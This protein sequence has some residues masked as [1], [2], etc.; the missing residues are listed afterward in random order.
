VGEG[1]AAE[2]STSERTAGLRKRSSTASAC[3]STEQRNSALHGIVATRSNPSAGDFQKDPGPV[4]ARARLGYG[5]R[6]RGV[7]QS[8][9][10]GSGRAAGRWRGKQRRARGKGKEGTDVRGRP[11]SEGGNRGGGRAHVAAVHV[12]RKER[13]LGLGR[14]D[15]AAQGKKR[16]ERRGLRGEGELGHRG[17]CGSEERKGPRER[18]RKRE[19]F[20]AGR[21]FSF[22][23]FSFSFLPSTI[24]TI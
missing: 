6:T 7:R 1:D 14:G 4:L 5:A 15:A 12:R 11:G 10:M 21:C 17:P 22:L 8:G 18:G 9:T 20:W 2:G 3:G 19:G 16:E 13:W 24:Q 23:S